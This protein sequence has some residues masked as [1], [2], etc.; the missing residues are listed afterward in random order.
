[1]GAGDSVRSAV[2]AAAALAFFF[3]ADL[4]SVSAVGGL[5]MMGAAIAKDGVPVEAINVD[6]MGRGFGNGQ[7]R[8]ELDGRTMSIP[9]VASD[10]R[11]WREG[12]RE[13]G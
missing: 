6:G 12:N 10:T 3:L 9:G 2:A 7:A 4:D 1:M 5:E 8:E 13:V 11:R